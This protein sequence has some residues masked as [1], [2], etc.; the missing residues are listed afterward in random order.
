MRIVY[1]EG[2]SS[3]NVDNY[4]LL[5]EQLPGSFSYHIKAYGDNNDIAAVLYA[6]KE[7]TK[8]KSV[9]DDIHDAINNGD[10]L[11]TI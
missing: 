5:I 2:K 7:F 8:V 3:I 11:I 10:R 6:D 4:T 9:L 1:N